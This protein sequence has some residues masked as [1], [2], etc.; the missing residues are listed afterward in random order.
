MKRTLILASITLGLLCTMLVGIYTAKATVI[1]DLNND[2]TVDMQDIGQVV[3]AFGMRLG[4]PRWDSTSDLDL[5]GKVDMHD[6]DLIIR[7]FGQKNTL[8]PFLVVPELPMGPL[9]GA[10]GCFTALGIFGLVKS[11]RHSR[12]ISRP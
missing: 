2:G 9:L 11:S 6:I 4:D 5:N 12:P 1:H 7:Q 8:D 10:V 3:A